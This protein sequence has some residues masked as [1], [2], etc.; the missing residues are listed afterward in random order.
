MMFPTISTLASDLSD[1]TDF[2]DD[3]LSENN[4]AQE[5]TP[6]CAC[7]IWGAQPK[8]DE[9]IVPTYNKPSGLFG[10]KSFGQV[11]RETQKSS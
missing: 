11:C 7:C 3:A 8:P 6:G 2:S 1:D 5:P 9:S 10:D 4:E